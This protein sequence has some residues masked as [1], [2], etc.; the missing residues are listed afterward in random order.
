M[1]TIGKR[2]ASGQNESAPKDKR[3]KTIAC[4]RCCRIKVRC[5]GDGY[6]QPPCTYC[7]SVQ[8]ECTYNQ[9]SRSKSSGTR[10][11]KNIQTIFFPPFPPNITV[12]ELIKPMNRKQKKPVKAPNAFMIYRINYSHEI[13]NDRKISQPEISSMSSQAWK[14]ESP[15]VKKTYFDFAKQAKEFYLAQTHVIAD[16]NIGSSQSQSMYE[17]VQATENDSLIDKNEIFEIN[18]LV[19]ETFET[20]EISFSHVDM[21]R[22]I[23]TLEYELVAKQNEIDSM[24]QTIFELNAELIQNTTFYI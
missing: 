16:D 1:N 8:L 17:D 6:N 21:Q 3:L 20:K 13:R 5:D 19:F 9:S 22:R 10:F 23:T 14:Q 2:L 24:R 12:N 15:N 7:T 18:P 4:D 11:E